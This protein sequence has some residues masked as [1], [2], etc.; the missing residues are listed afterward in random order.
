MYCYNCMNQIADG[1]N[2]CPICNKPT[3][4][5]PIAHHILPGTILNGKYTIGNVLGE[6]GFGITYV[7]LDNTLQV[8]VAIKEF[9][10]SGYAN[11]NH[12][13][14]NE[15]ILT[16]NKQTDFFANGKERFLQEARSLAKFTGEV[17]IVN[18][19]D[20][21]ECNNTAYIV[22]EFL[23]GADL[24]NFMK[25]HGTFKAEDIF[26]LMMP[27]MRSLEKIHASGIIHRDI[28]PE[29]IMRLQSGTLKLMDLGS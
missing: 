20:F 28:S 8:K 14:S 6:G 4:S 15:V 27:V 7:G 1:S 10:P 13:Q 16:T 19:R 23:D 17:G 22:M 12:T 24:N 18:V 2:V 5:A 25:T 29:N 9:F 21:F 3:S 11:R 26:A